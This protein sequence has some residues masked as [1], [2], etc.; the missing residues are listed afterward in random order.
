[1]PLELE[2]V[3]IEREV[4]TAD[5]VDM[6][7][8]PGEDG[9][10]GVMPRHEPMV[11][12]LREGLLEIVRGDER[13]HLAIGGGFM[14]VH[15]TKVIV[16]ADVAERAD[17]IDVERAERARKRAEKTLAEA[18]DRIEARKALADMRRASVRI[19]VA[20][21]RTHYRRRREDGE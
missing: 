4:Y 18:P 16:M 19:K 3:T 14:E 10:M 17:E 7:I 5:D 13:E 8:A 6:V 11:V 1:M 12:N 2:V 15:A 20:R 9:V 21:R